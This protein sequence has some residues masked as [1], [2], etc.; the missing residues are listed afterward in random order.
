MESAVIVR[1][2][3]PDALDRLRRRCVHDAGLDMPAHVTMLYPFVEP[4]GLTTAVRGAVASI[5]SAHAS[6]FFVMSGPEQW[7]DTVYAA[8]NP[9]HRFL[10]IHDDLALAFPD[11]PIYGRPGFEL[12]PHVTIAEGEY[13]GNSEVLD[14]PAWSSLP[15]YG[16]VDELEVIAEGRDGRWRTVWTLP[17]ATPE[18]SF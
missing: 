6:F 5:A 8:V 9:E 7:P 17:L 2:E 11:Y 4:T 18:L 13:V 3:L 14:H 15:P 16:S 1:V 12:I 10:G